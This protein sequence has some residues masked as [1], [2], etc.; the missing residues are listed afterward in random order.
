MFANITAAVPHVK[1]GTMRAIAASG[2][3]RSL[4]LPT[5]PTVAE[6]GVPGYAWPLDTVVDDFATLMT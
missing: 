5:L 3:A 2:A 1:T 4:A 6:A